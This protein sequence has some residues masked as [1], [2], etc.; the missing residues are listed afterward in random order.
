MK[1]ICTKDEDGE[2]EIFTFPR[3]VDHDCMA[4]MLNKIKNHS[5]GNWK[6]VRR[7]P[8][9]AGFVND[10]GYCFGESITLDIKSRGDVDTEILLKQMNFPQY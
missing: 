5:T 1:Y 4:E 9:S 2:E 7:K 8:V 6:R 10:M 3:S